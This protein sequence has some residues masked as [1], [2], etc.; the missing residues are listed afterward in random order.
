M[1]VYHIGLLFVINEMQWAVAVLGCNIWG[2][3]PHGER[4]IA[5][6]YNGGMGQS[7]QRGPGAEPLVRGSGKAPWNWSTF[8]FWTF[9]ESRTFV[10]FSAIWKSKEIRYLCYLYKKSWVAAKLGAGAK[11]GACAPPFSGHGLKPPLTMRLINVLRNVTISVYVPFS[12]LSPP[13]C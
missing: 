2:T 8:G 4:G 1:P 5:R 6:D 9:N 11:M 13:L 12:L 10:H 7:P 3:R